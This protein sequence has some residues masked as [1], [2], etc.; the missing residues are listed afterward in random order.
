MQPPSN[1]MPIPNAG[2]N[3]WTPVGS[4]NAVAGSWGSVGS[5]GNS[6][7]RPLLASSLI[8]VST[9]PSS[10]E[11]L[12]TRSGGNLSS[13]SSF[14]SNASANNPSANL[15]T[16][17]IVPQNPT[18]FNYL[19]SL[20]NSPAQA[21]A[22]QRSF[23]EHSGE[24]AS[25]LS[26]SS[27]GSVQNS[28]LPQNPPNSP[29]RWPNSAAQFT[30]GGSQTNAGAAYNPNTG[31]IPQSFGA[32][33]GFAQPPSVSTGQRF[34]S[35][36]ANP[37]TSAQMSAGQMGRGQMGPG[38][39]STGQMGPGQMSAGQMNAG[40]MGRGQMG[41]GQMNA[42]LMGRGQMGPSQ[43]S[44]GLMGR[45]QMGPGQM[46]A[47]PM[48][49]G[50]MGPGQMN[51]GLMGRGQM[52]PGQMSA[53]LM[54]RG[55]MGPGQMSAGQMGRGQVTPS[56]MGDNQMPSASMGGGQTNAAQMNP[57]QTN[58]TQGAQGGSNQEDEYLQFNF[59]EDA[60]NHNFAA[61]YRRKSSSI[62]SCSPVITL[63][64]TATGLCFR[65]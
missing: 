19:A 5:P 32:Y 41:P 24:S 35:A 27:A 18:I 11:H 21:P 20:Q 39:M 17:Q 7:P 23:A 22:G 3:P 48:G 46:S 37:A 49:R 30:A 29:T 52:G 38:Q 50:Q 13:L 8:S 61:P 28:G 57:G 26:L 1:P 9:T 31:R 40:L 55:Q 12:N 43:M 64:D 59:S 34:G 65:L 2:T 63:T 33:G 53:G 14:Q 45:G 15:S 36:P 47:G 58:Q 60:D 10:S 62:A 16:S 4:S 42:G 44:A 54:G 51:A 25:L 56:L 6:A